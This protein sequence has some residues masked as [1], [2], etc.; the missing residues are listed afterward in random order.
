MTLLAINCAWVRD[1]R[2]RLDG[3]PRGREQSPDEDHEPDT[4]SRHDIGVLIEPLF[5]TNGV[6]ENVVEA[7][8]LPVYADG[9]AGVTEPGLWVEAR[10]RRW[11]DRIEVR[12]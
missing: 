3:P 8:L 1:E 7:K 12:E 4:L 2:E 9:V 6:T 10:V 5:D 11:G